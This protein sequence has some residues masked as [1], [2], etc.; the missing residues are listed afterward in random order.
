M[1]WDTWTDCLVGTSSTGIDVV[2]LE[3]RAAV[4][5]VIVEHL[6]KTFIT[7]FAGAA[8]VLLISIFYRKQKMAGGGAA[9]MVG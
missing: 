9:A 6:R 8:G 2:P 3:M 1:H 4:I 5:D 7:A